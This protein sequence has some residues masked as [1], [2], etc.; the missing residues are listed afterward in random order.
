MFNHALE[1]VADFEGKIMNSSTSSDARSIGSELKNNLGSVG[2]D[3]K[4]SAIEAKDYVSKAASD[5]TEYGKDAVSKTGEKVKAAV[6]EKAH[7]AA[8]AAYSARDSVS[9]FIEERP[10]TSVLIAF[11]VGVIASRLIAPSRH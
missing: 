9:A 4:E 6:V 5:A 11:T 10:F 2:R 1:A 3:M 7:Q 8:D